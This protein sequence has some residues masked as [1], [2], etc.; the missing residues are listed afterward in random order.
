MSREIEGYRDALAEIMEAYPGK[1]MLSVKEAAEFLNC[2]RRTVTALVDRGEL[3]GCNVGLG[4]Y[5]I[6][7]VSVKDLAKFRGGRAR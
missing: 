2:D 5:K 6:Y 7:R 4:K 3:V 1:K